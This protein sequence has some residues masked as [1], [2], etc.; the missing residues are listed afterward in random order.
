MRDC[1][2]PEELVR[3]RAED[4]REIA[5]M[6]AGKL[7]GRWRYDR[8]FPSAASD[9]VAGDALGDKMTDGT[10]LVE[11]LD[12]DMSGSLLWHRTALSVGW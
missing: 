4:V 6:Q 7:P 1:R 9:V 8:A 11:L 2:T 12:E 10:Y 5:D 3:S